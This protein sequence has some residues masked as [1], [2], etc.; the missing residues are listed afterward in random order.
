MKPHSLLTDSELEEV[1]LL[2]AETIPGKLNNSRRMKGNTYRCKC[3]K[4]FHSWDDFSKHYLA[5]QGE[6]L[7][8]SP[9]VKSMH[10]FKQHYFLLDNALTSIGMQILQKWAA[11]VFTAS[12]KDEDLL[13]W[14]W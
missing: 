5:C 12:D 10:E 3:K 11:E 8:S 7:G 14:W 9:V 2:A 1:K 13:N 4:D 6:K